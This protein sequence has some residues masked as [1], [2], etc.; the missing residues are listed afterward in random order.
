MYTQ[1]TVNKFLHRPLPDPKRVQTP[2]SDIGLCKW[3]LSWWLHRYIGR[4][5][6]DVKIN[7]RTVARSSYH[8]PWPPA[9][10]S[11]TGQLGGLRGGQMPRSPQLTVSNNCLFCMHMCIHVCMHMS[12][13]VHR[14]VIIRVIVK[15]KAIVRCTRCRKGRLFSSFSKRI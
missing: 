4:E 11:G 13:H 7:K 12:I 6:T 15:F 10:T 2:S 3:W 14:R 1:F 8:H 9:S 5:M